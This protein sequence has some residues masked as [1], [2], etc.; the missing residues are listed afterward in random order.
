MP[1]GPVGFN[2]TNEGQELHEMI[3]A[4]FKD[5]SQTIEELIELPEKEAEKAVTTLGFMFAN[6]GEGDIQTFDLEPATYGTV[7]FIPVG[8]TPDKDGEGPPHAFEGMTAQFTV[9]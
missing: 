9:E 4:R 8:T 1:A 2:L 6:P 7:C 3:I 5:P